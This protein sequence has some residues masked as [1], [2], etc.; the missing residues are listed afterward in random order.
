[1][2]LYRKEAA[3]IFGV[4]SMLAEVDFSLHSLYAN[5]ITIEQRVHGHHRNLELDGTLETIT[6]SFHLTI[7]ITEIE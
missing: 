2:F 1:M 4:C 5:L 6:H 7:G 3:G